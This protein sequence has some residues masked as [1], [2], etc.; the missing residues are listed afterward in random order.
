M[1]R[2]TSHILWKF[3]EHKKHVW[4]H[5]PVMISSLVTHLHFCRLGAIRKSSLYSGFWWDHHTRASLI[6]THFP[7]NGWFLHTTKQQKKMVMTG[8]WCKWHFIYFMTLFLPT[9]I[10]ILDLK[11][12]FRSKGQPQ[13][14]LS[15][16]RSQGQV[17]EQNPTPWAGRGFI[18]VSGLLLLRWS[19]WDISHFWYV[20]YYTNMAPIINWNIKHRHRYLW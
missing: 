13:S 4:N 18:D 1:G 20:I 19:F 5:Q 14:L 8:G 9:L 11:I 17:L 3:M 6:T 15:E 10:R 12:L 16:P 7:G 2:M